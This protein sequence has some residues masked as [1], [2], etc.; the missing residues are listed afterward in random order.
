MTHD[1]FLNFRLMHRDIL[2]V[3]TGSPASCYNGG[4]RFSHPFRAYI[5]AYLPCSHLNFPKRMGH[6]VIR[7]LR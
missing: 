6:P 1:P 4:W 7:V 2:M 5:A 3:A